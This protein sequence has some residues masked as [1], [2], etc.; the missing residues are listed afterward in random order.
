MTGSFLTCRCR[1]DFDVPGV[2]SDVGRVADTVMLDGGDA[3]VDKDGGITEDPAADGVS[4]ADDGP[5]D[6]NTDGTTVVGT[7]TV[8]GS[9]VGEGDGLKSTDV[10]FATLPFFPMKLISFTGAYCTSFTPL[11]MTQYAFF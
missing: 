10:S 5:G 7:I 11:G 3:M 1:G 6:V 4:A 8:H 2:G 9:G